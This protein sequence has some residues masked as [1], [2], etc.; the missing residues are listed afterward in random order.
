MMSAIDK[1]NYN[2][3]VRSL[4]A[5]DVKLVLAKNSR[6]TESLYRFGWFYINDYKYSVSGW[7]FRKKIVSFEDALGNKVK[8]SIVDKSTFGGEFKKDG[9]F[10]SIKKKISNGLA[11]WLK[12]ISDKLRT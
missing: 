4:D 2:E 5:T 1:T 11:N 12:D 10:L 8:F 9:T 6:D 7:S 3:L